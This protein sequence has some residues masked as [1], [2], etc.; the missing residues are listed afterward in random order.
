[1]DSAVTPPAAP[2]PAAPHALRIRRSGSD[3]LAVVWFPGGLQVGVLRRGAL[4][5]HWSS[6]GAPDSLEAFAAELDNAL[7]SLDFSGSD[8]VLVLEHAAFRHSFEA[9]PPLSDSATRNY[10]T[11]RI[12][13]EQP[14]DD[15]LLW[16]SQPLHSPKKE[17]A[18]LLHLLPT[19]LYQALNGVFID[20]QL[21]LTRIIPATVPLLQLAAPDIGAKPVV[22][23]AELGTSVTCSVIDTNGNLLLNRS[24]RAA[25]DTEADRIGVEVNRCALFIKQRFALAVSDIRLLGRPNDATTTEVK[26][27]CAQG[28]TIETRAVTA[29]DWLDAV[30]RV[31]LRQPVNL[32]SGYL[33]HKR[34]IQLWRKGLIAAAWLGFLVL[35]T[36]AVSIVQQTGDQRSHLAQLATDEATL[37]AERERL[38]TRNAV[39]EANQ[40]TI[41]EIQVARDLALPARILATVAAST[42]ASIDLTEST[43]RFDAGISKWQVRLV[44][45]LHTDEFSAPE[46]LSS[47]L[48]T[49]ARGTPA[50]DF[51]EPLRAIVNGGADSPTLQRFSVE[52]GLREP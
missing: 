43:I 17:K 50:L 32:L 23:A 26:R 46:M 34:Q 36:S 48:N 5:S 9:L 11:Q 12:Q 4:V 14:A 37:R 30:A 3:A 35:F 7:T 24:F 33:S 13:R 6:S 42:P 15:P 41:D 16:V 18:V 21:D 49:L 22:L 45:Q 47:W 8:V 10:L 31:P 19:S 29:R 2:A 20:R 51:P 44:G 52:G 38:L 1:M 28:S 40:Q 25:W 27:R 39:A